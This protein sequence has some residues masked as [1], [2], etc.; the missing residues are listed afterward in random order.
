MVF[1]WDENK[2]QAN[3]RKHGVSFEEAKTIFFS[4]HAIVFD[5]F[6]SK[7][8]EERF[9]IVGFSFIGRLL[10]CCFCERGRSKE[11]IRIISARK[12]SKNEIK[13]FSERWKK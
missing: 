5:D 3:L 9:L 11:V 13:S 6:D 1:E 4:E 2:S 7:E 8:K 10:I 12:L